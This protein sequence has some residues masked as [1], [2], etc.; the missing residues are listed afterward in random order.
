MAG[1]VFQWQSPPA[2]W[3]RTQMVRSTWARKVGVKVMA[4]LLDYDPPEL[5]PPGSGTP[6]LEPAG[7]SN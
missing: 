3:L 7:H 4:Q 5:P 1:K 6:S 2:V